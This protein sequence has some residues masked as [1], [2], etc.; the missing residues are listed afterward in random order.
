MG[1]YLE[2]VDYAAKL[3]KIHGRLVFWLPVPIEGF[4][5]DDLPN[6]DCLKY[7]CSPIQHLSTK[8]G[9]RLI[10]LEKI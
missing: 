3:L 10:V 7:I 8:Y 5:I 2:T 1:I 4:S 9:R 6:N